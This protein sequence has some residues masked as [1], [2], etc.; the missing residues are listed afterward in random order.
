MLTYWEGLIQTERSCGQRKGEVCWCGQRKGEVCCCGQRKDEVCWSGQRK[1][2][3]CCCGQR[4]DEVGQA[5][6]VVFSWPWYTMLS[7]SSHILSTIGLCVWELS[8]SYV[9]N[10][11]CLYRFYYYLFKSVFCFCAKRWITTNS[12]SLITILCF[13]RFPIKCSTSLWFHG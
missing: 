1:G 3:V 11:L 10:N 9:F 6:L 8:I 7:N 12:Q 5:V 4:K 13:D 2:E